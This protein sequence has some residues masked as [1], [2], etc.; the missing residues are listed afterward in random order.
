MS[1]TEKAYPKGNPLPEEIERIVKLLVSDY[2]P[3]KIILFGSY[4]YGKPDASSDIDLFIIKRTPKRWLER[5]KEVRAILSDSQRTTALETL[6]F[7]PNEVEEKLRIGDAFFL[8]I[9]ERGRVLYE[10]A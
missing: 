2:Q 1:R 7:T 4:A 10:A 6:V 5:W 9:M 8:E 3:Q